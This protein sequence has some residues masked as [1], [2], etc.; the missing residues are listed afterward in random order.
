M[1]ELLVWSLSLGTTFLG[2]IHGGPH[3]Q[4]KCAIYVRGLQWK[5]KTHIAITPI[6]GRRNSTTV[7]PEDPR[8]SCCLFLH[9]CFM[10]A[11]LLSRTAVPRPHAS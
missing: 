5:K 10:K 4:G 3:I 9:P 2:D 1:A 8:A 6:I 7:S 11:H